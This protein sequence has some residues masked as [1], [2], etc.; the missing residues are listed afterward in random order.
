MNYPGKPPLFFSTNL[1]I[2]VLKMKKKY[3]FFP[4]GEQKY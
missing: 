4:Q 3:W 2:K 1:V